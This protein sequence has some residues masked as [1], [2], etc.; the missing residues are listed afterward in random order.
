M[1]EE[2]EA[3]GAV[4]A[5][6]RNVCVL[7]MGLVGG[8]G[9][10]RS[11][12]EGSC[13]VV[14]LRGVTVRRTFG[15]CV[16]VQSDAWRR[17]CGE[18]G[19]HALSHGTGV[20]CPVGAKGGHLVLTLV[21]SCNSPRHCWPGPPCPCPAAQ[22]RQISPGARSRCADALV[23]APDSQLPALADAFLEQLREGQKSQDC[24]TPT[25]NVTLPGALLPVRSR[26][27]V[28]SHQEH[29]Q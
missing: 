20:T 23:P 10:Q 7:L 12:Q 29:S 18:S 2:E 24:L 26:L 13:A 27:W 1:E 28:H 9:E 3:G 16:T 15:D 6:W 21:C 5:G 4:F 17:V 11:V 25:V 14:R 8:Q 22:H 19:N